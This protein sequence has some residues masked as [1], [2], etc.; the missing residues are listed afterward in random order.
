[1]L[2]Q[3]PRPPEP[4]VLLE[5]GPARFGVGLAAVRIEGGGFQLGHLGRK[6]GHLLGHLGGKVVPLEWIAL[7][8][9]EAAVSAVLDVR[10]RLRVEVRGAVRV[11]RA[12]VD[13]LDAK[14]M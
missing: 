1:M 3:D 2:V 7:E 6:F 11:L 8:L 9:K 5:G 14:R 10:W 13:V 12:E 4:A